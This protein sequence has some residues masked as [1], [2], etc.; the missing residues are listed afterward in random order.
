M[1]TK[2]E[3]ERGIYNKFNITRTDG[4]DAPGGK[5]HGDEYFVLNLTTDKN[6]I[7]AIAAYAAACAAEYP[8]LAAIFSAFLEIM[9]I[10]TIAFEI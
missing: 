6:A 1:N 5:H 10:I 7:P 3:Y 9:L 8:A 2:N 4:T